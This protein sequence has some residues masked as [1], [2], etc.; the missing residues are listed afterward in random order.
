[1]QGPVT[2]WEGHQKNKVHCGGGSSLNPLPSWKSF[3]HL[4]RPTLNPPCALNPREKNPPCVFLNA[5]FLSGGLSWNSVYTKL[6]LGA[7]YHALSPRENW[8]SLG[9]EFD[10]CCCFWATFVN[11]F[12]MS[13]EVMVLIITPVSD[14]SIFWVLHPTD[15]DGP[16][17]LVHSWTFLWKVRDGREGT[18]GFQFRPADRSQANLALVR[19]LGSN[20]DLPLTC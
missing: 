14:L 4:V 19:C 7:L 17:S 16:F 12:R 3:S 10:G 18:D 1:M 9:Q 20:L 11:V 15:L 8:V 13:Q 2:S 5:G 6:P